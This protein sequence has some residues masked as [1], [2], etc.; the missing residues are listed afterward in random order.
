M[1][2]HDKSLSHKTIT[3][4]GILCVFLAASLASNIYQYLVRVESTYKNADNQVSSVFLNGDPYHNGGLSVFLNNGLIVHSNS[5]FNVTVWYHRAAC[6]TQEET[7]EKI[8]LRIF[9]RY[10]YEEYPTTPLAEGTFI[11]NKTEEYTGVTVSAGTYVLVAPS[12]FGTYIFRIWSG[13]VGQNASTTHYT[14]E[15]AI[16]AKSG[17]WI[18]W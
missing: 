18:P 16:W 11:L 1:E 5:R 8:T 13:I 7:T 6:V 12:G 4:V 9:G 14:Q 17:N 3:I 15:F 2:Q 10:L